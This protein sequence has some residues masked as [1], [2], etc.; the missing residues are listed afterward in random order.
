MIYF[1]GELFSDFNS[2][3]DFTEWFF[4]LDY[5]WESLLLLIHFLYSHGLP[6][7]FILCIWK[8]KKF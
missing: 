3:K 8:K 6:F 4:L 2:N 1:L 5:K 7:Y